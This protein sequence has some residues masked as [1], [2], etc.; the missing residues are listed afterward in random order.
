MDFYKETGKKITASKIKE[1]AKKVGK[2]FLTL[3]FGGVVASCETGHSYATR[4]VYQYGN[5]IHAQTTTYSE[6][7]AAHANY[8]NA[9]AAA[10]LVNSVV[11]LTGAFGRCYVHHYPTPHHPPRPVRLHIH[12][13]HHHYHHHCR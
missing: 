6:V 3:S 12:R 10:I 5:G 1:N 13:P 11:G 9:N 8:L 7:D 2:M 4:S